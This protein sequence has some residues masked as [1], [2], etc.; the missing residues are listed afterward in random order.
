MMIHLA[1]FA[2]QNWPTATAVFARERPPA[3]VCEIAAGSMRARVGKPLGRQPRGRASRNR[4]FYPRAGIY[5]IGSSLA[6][7]RKIAAPTGDGLRKERGDKRICSVIACGTVALSAWLFHIGAAIAN[8]TTAQLSTGGLDFVPNPNV[9][10]R[11]E[12][13]F[14]SM[15]QIR[16]T[17]H[18]FNKSDQPVTNLIAF[19]MPDIT[20][21][22][23]DAHFAIPTEDPVNFLGFT[24]TVNGQRV[25]VEVQ[26]TAHVK[27]IDQT[28]LLQQLRIPLA[29][30]LQATAEALDAL[31]PDKRQRLIGLGLAETDDS[32]VGQS[33]IQHL[34]PRWTLKTT[35]Y[36]QQ[37]FPAHEDL[38]IAHQY[39]PSVGVTVGTQ[40]GD[41]EDPAPAD[42]ET[43]YCTDPD[44]IT[45][46][47][48]ARAAARRANKAFGEKRID[49][50]LT[51]GANWASPIA[52]F[53]LTVDKGDPANL[54]SFCGTGVKKIAPTQFQVHHTNF[55]PTA[56]L[57]ILILTN[58][59]ATK[60]DL[61]DAGGDLVTGVYVD[62]N[63]RPDEWV[64]DVH[65]VYSNGTDVVAPKEKDQPASTS[66]AVAED[67]RTVGWLAEYPVGGQ[68]YPGPTT[69][70]IYRDKRI[71]TR[72]EASVGIIWDWK[73]FDKGKQ[74]GF[75]EGVTH[76]TLIP[77]DYRLYD[78]ATGNLIQRVETANE[79]S[80]KWA[81][82]LVRVDTK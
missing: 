9:E 20:F 34:Q 75:T 21:D 49:Y 61:S 67:Q 2:G 35:Y 10:M 33:V 36:W 63:G 78:V 64:Q 52:D 38:M 13:L 42:Y 37:T 80:P 14:V 18:F 19:P 51:T 50:I 73:F 3:T 27:G 26:Q 57:A 25:P 4:I 24:T 72:I 29:P 60:P 56:D 66:P 48:R 31:P 23:P 7:L 62:D 6:L 43:K 46:A 22:N 82:E 11:S 53:M 65:I 12:E 71:I 44:L 55:T 17:Y 77:E 54:V 30:Q 40:V 69:L 76:G 81:K 32:Y 59:V 5:R 39:K 8:D 68:S 16:V 41:L 79:Q 74:V 1:E 70:V 15:T 45:A 47:T 28:A 58:D